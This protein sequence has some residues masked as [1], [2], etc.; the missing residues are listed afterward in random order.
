MKFDKKEHCPVCRMTV[1][2][3][4]YSM[5]HHKLE[6]HF[7]S[8][9]CR[10]TFQSRPGLY[11]GNKAKELGEIIKR[12]PLRLAEALDEEASRVVIQRLKEMMGVKEVLA[13]ERLLIIRYDLLQLNLAQLEAALSNSGIG[14]DKGWWQQLRRTWFKNTEQNELNNLDAPAG[15]CC[16]RPPP[17]V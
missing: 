14:L 16:S 13:R 7:C 5:E 9:Q 8:D 17:R 11:R 15:A 1:E 2:N 6:Y 10:E 12:R 3:D 4:D